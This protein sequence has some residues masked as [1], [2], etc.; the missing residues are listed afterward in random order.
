MQSP[1][2][3]IG[4]NETAL[5]TGVPYWIKVNIA[6]LK[7]SFLGDF[8]ENRLKGPDGEDG[9]TASGGAGFS[10]QHPL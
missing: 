7:E 5:G 10:A 3:K 9:G 2:F 4:M 6:L 8:C 1:G